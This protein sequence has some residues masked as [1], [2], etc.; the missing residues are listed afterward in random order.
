MH[1]P[2]IQPIS[3]S[4]QVINIGYKQSNLLQ[5]REVKAF[6]IIIFILFYI[7]VPLLPVVYVTTSVRIVSVTTSIIPVLQWAVVARVVKTLSVQS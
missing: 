4:Q 5:D 2:F 3:Q 1:N 7:I 6:C